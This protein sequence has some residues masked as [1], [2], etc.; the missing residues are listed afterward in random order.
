VKQNGKGRCRLDANG[1]G[2]GPVA[3][4]GNEPSGSMSDDELLRKDSAPWSQ[5]VMLV[6]SLHSY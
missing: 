2:E 5:S 3:V 4:H 1:S 6:C